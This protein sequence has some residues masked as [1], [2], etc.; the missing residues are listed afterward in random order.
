[1]GEGEEERWE[2]RAEERE[3]ESEGTEREAER[4][5]E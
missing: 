3:V 5:S 2:L 1:M 4:W